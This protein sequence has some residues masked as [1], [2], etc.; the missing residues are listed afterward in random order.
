MLDKILIKLG[1][2][3]EEKPRLKLRKNSVSIIGVPGRHSNDM[4]YNQMLL[5]QVATYECQLFGSSFGRVSTLGGHDS[6]MALGQEM[7]HRKRMS[8]EG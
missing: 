1:L 4:A 5:Q 6:L 7:A 3:K 8:D 2:I